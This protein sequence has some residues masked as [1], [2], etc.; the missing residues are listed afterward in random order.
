[1]VAILLMT[2]IDDK[3]HQIILAIYL[4]VFCFDV[5]S[6]LWG[7]GL[8]ASNKVTDFKVKRIHISDILPFSLAICTLYIGRSIWSFWQRLNDTFSLA[9]ISKQWCW[10]WLDM[11]G[12][13]VAGCVGVLLR[14]GATTIRRTWSSILNFVIMHNLEMNFNVFWT[15]G[16]LFGGLLV[17]R[18]R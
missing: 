18:V 12:R 17:R 13:N 6:Y 7:I 4:A 1:M 9:C 3:L 2:I 10:S 16:D 11:F 15:I 5:A 8:I 14:K